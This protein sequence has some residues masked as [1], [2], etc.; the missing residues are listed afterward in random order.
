MPFII[1][2]NKELRISWICKRLPLSEIYQG[3]SQE[4]DWGR[5]DQGDQAM[6]GGRRQGAG[7]E[8]KLKDVRPKGNNE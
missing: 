7:V 3:V 2:F 1:L 4:K 5:G 6:F 8:A